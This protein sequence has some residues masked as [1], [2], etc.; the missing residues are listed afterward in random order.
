MKDIAII[1]NLVGQRAT[2]EDMKFIDCFLHPKLGLFIP[3]SG[4]CGY[5]SRENHSHPSYMVTIL[6]DKSAKK[7]NHYRGEIISPGIKHNDYPNLN[8]YALC[9]EKEYFEQNYLLYE[10]SVPLFEREAFEI[11]DEVL[12]Y[13]NMFAFESSK[14]MANSDITMGA[15]VELVV[16]WIIR[17]ILGESMD[18]RAVS[19]DYSIARAQHFMEQHFGEKITVERLAGLSYVSAS[20]LTHKFKKELGISPI[21]YLIDIRIQKSKK[22]LQR[23]QLPLTEVA[24][25]CGFSS[26]Y[27]FCRAF[28]QK[29]GMTPSQYAHQM[30][31]QGL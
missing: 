7:R 5:A 23:G 8:Y 19:A 4:S 28:R 16:H 1:K 25:L 18:M 6:F 20:S 15:H 2:E 11:C 22:Y 30:R 10:D 21:E 13:L 24:V 31:Q 29:V 3:I 27:H 26:L 17:S 9:I 12:R 14:S